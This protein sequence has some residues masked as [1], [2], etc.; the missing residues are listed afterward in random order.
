MLSREEVLKIA[1]LARLELT[2]EEVAHYQKNL[3]RVLHHMEELN[4]LEAPKGALVRHVPRDAVAVREDVPVKFEDRD[5]L[6][7][8]APQM[9]GQSFVLPVVLEE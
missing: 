4:K 3:T 7:A 6:L 9:E 2:D 5:A 8:N 1:D